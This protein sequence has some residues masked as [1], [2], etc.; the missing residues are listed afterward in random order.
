M[1]IVRSLKDTVFIN[2][3]GCYFVKL[4]DSLIQGIAITVV[5]IN[6]SSIQFFVKHLHHL[7]ITVSQGSLETHPYFFPEANR[8]NLRKVKIDKYKFLIIWTIHNVL[9]F[10]I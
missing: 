9:R 5:G 7:R 4:N 1:F 2:N 3:L 10:D 8:N 6:E